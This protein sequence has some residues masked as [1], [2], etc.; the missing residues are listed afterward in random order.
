MTD[1][2]YAEQEAR[3]ADDKAARCTLE[4]PGDTCYCTRRDGCR[5]DLFAD[6]TDED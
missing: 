2:Q 3:E 1:G 6:D 5:E 4:W